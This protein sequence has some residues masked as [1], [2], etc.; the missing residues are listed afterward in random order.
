[1]RTAIILVIALASVGTSAS[2]TPAI[3]SDYATQAKQA[4]PGFT[5]FAADRGKTLYFRETLQNGKKISCATCHSADP[6]QAGKTLA[7]RTID[8]MATSVTPSRFTDS[9]KV[10]KWF[11]RN[12]DD[13]FKRECTPLEKGDFITYL[14]SLK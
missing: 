7:F 3:I 10:E 4:N 11:R 8:P 14:S 5:G 13:V 1:M 6:R 2:A 12:C 9:K